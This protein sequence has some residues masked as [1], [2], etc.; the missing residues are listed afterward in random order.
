MENEKNFV[1]K[2]HLQK[3]RHQLEQ[4]GVDISVWGKGEAKTLEA[5]YQELEKGESFLQVVDGRLELLRYVVSANVYY[6]TK[7]G[8][9]IRLQ[10]D[11]QIFQ[12]GRIRHRNFDDPIADKM[13]PG[14]DSKAAMLRCLEEE[15]GLVGDLDLKQ[16]EQYQ[17]KYESQSYP[18]LESQYIVYSFAVFLNDEQFQETGYIE[19]QD[20]K[21]TYFVWEEVK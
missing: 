21:T 5:L 3:L 20:D 15:L 12:D 2:D 18:G 9:K 19:E 7:D 11:K 14:E 16:I 4:A 6:T 13:Q 8:L 10:E 17:K 1:E